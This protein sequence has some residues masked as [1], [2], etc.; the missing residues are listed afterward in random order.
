MKL[1]HAPRLY[2]YLAE[3]DVPAK[4]VT[5]AARAREAGYRK[6]EAYTPFPIE[7]L[8]HAL[9]YHHS[10][11]P[12]LVLAGGICGALGGFGLCYW[13]STIAYPMNIG[14]RPFNSWPSFIP[15]TF[16][17]TVLLAALS[18][19]FGMLA[20]NGLPMPHHP[21]FNVDRFAHAS[22]DRYFLCIQADDPRFERGATQ[23][24]LLSLHPS[25][26]SKV[27]Y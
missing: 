15:V 27:E 22:R 16:E 13:T 23:E 10:W 18:A 5:A 17:C 24:F 7:E 1:E 25:E 19:V 14:G 4:L 11:V 26:V 20:L 3:F 6:M 2:G 9:G 21:V 8:N 12:Y